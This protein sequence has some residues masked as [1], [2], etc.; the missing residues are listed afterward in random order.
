MEWEL[1]ADFGLQ[2]AGIIELHELILVTA[3]DMVYQDR[4]TQASP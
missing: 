1:S 4:G 3:Q 2:A